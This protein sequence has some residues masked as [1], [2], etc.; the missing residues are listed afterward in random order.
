MLAA[1]RPVLLKLPAESAQLRFGMIYS[2]F[3]LA[4]VS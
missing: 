1:V 2:I 3:D 4:G